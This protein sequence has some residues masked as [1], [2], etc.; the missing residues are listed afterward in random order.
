MKHS[1]LFRRLLFISPLVLSTALLSTCSVKEAAPEPAG[2]VK[3]FFTQLIQIVEQNSINRYKIDWPNYKDQVWAKVGSAKTIVEAES[4]MV[5]A[6]ALLKDN[7]SQIVIDN[8]RSL[9]GGVG[10]Q[11]APAIT[12]S[13]IAEPAIGYVEVRGFSGT[14]PEG[15]ALAQ[16]I[17]NDIARQDDKK[18][19]GWIVDLRRNVG[20]NMY[21]MIAGLGPL[22][23]E[24]RCGNFYDAD[25]NLKATYAYQNGVALLNQSSMVA[26]S[27]PYRLLNENANVA[28]LIGSA[29]AS[30]GEATTIAFVGRANTR[31]FGA[32]SCGVSTGNSQYDLPFYGYRLNL[33]TVNIGDRTGKIYGGEIKP[34]ELVTEDQVLARAV[35]WINQ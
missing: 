25:N 33:F 12:T 15:I 11:A 24:G 6:L 29:T 8:K 3:N 9:Y 13:T 5:L 32:A 26:V 19:K 4:A 20:G 22:L 17:Q 10:C 21:P 7:H 31:L 14:D 35:K 34:D 2:P 16:A 18:L 1:S 27:R 30:S 28:V 23:G